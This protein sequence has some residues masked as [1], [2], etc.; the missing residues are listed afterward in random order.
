[1]KNIMQGFWKRL[2]YLTVNHIQWNEISTCSGRTTHKYDST[3][4]EIT[5]IYRDKSESNLYSREELILMLK[6][7]RENEAAQNWKVPEWGVIS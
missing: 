2:F 6:T 4:F 7:I 5:V 1:M 3:S